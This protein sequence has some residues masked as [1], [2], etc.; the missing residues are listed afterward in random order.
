MAEPSEAL[1]ALAHRVIGAAIEVHRELGAGFLESVYEQAPCVELNRQGIAFVRQAA[2]PI[3]YK[4]EPVGD[5]RLDLLVEGA[6]VVELK[7][8]ETLAP[9]HAAQVKNYLKATSHQLALLIN[10]NVSVLKDGLKRIVLTP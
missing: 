9:I 8:V 5:A 4:N 1:D 2:V 10:F 3:R 6:L 7:A